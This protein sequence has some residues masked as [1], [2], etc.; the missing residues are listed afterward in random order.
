MDILSEMSSVYYELTIS[1]KRIAEYILD[2]TD[3]VQMMSIS[4]LAEACHVGEATITRFCKRFHSRGYTALKIE[5]VKLSHPSYEPFS[6]SQESETTTDSTAHQNIGGMLYGEYSAAMKQ[7]AELLKKEQV[8]RAVEVLS[9]AEIVYC[10]GQGG[11][12]II[13]MEA[14]HLFSTASGKFFSVTD[15]HM[16]AIAIATAGENDVIL[17]FSYSGATKDLI[18]TLSYARERGLRSILVTHFANSPG[19]GLADVT[20]L[21]G[22]DESPLQL[23]SV[24]ARIAQMYLLD[25]LFSE[26][27]RRNLDACRQSRARI[28]AAL[29]DKHL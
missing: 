4:E 18:E 8:I 23:G 6:D 10:M 7:T 12:M 13:A 5:L 26:L 11:S 29:A 20:L 1:E 3:E 24:G 16:Q 9:Q 27:C 2:H 15:S 17:F 25:V 21:C 22:A 19:A 28:A 14:A